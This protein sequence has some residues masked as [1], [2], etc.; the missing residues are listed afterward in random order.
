MMCLESVKWA[1][2][3]IVLDSFST[4]QTLGIAKQYH[5]R[6]DQHDFLGYGLQ[7]QSALEKTTH[8]WVLLLDADEAL[9]Q[10]LQI[11]IQELLARGPDADGY[12]L[13]RLEQVFWRMCNRHVRLNYY[14]RLFN[15]H[16]GGISD[17]P[18]HAAPKV[19][20]RIRRLRY[21]FYH[22]GERDIHTK[23]DKVN[24]YSSGL[25][26]DKV[27]K[28]ISANPL[29]MVFYP[30]FVFFRL[31]IFKRNF[32]NGWAGFISSIIG[33]FYAFMKYAKLFEYYRKHEAGQLAERPSLGS[34]QTLK[35]D[36]LDNE[37]NT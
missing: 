35:P 18:I 15:K 2:E 32:L 19:D 36:N 3:I 11:E 4:D 30:P 31:Y 16:K 22:Y 9:S 34:T 12:A 28:K 37:S 33:A 7:K 25:V 20:G 23:V 21:P 6:I 27:S 8:D 29:I 1:D 14:L 17:M 10:D 13:P 24:T 26:E 5:C